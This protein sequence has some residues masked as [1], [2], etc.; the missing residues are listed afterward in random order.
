METQLISTFYA[1]ESD[2]A[3]SWKYNNVMEEADHE[4]GPHE[5]GSRD[6]ESTFMEH[7][8]SHGSFDAIRPATEMVPERESTALSIAQLLSPASV[9]EYPRLEV[10]T[11]GIL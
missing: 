4:L 6:G 11:L 2:V 8:H 5:L 3:K 1:T 10:L 9:H 7:R